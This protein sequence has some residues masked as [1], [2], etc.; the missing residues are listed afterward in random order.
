MTTV[1]EYYS[2]LRTQADDNA[3]LAAFN[4]W[5]LAQPEATRN[6]IVFWIAN[7]VAEGVDLNAARLLVM[8]AIDLVSAEPLERARMID[9]GKAIQIMSEWHEIDAR[10]RV[11][12]MA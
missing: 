7:I 11:R 4:E 12:L 10:R 5:L 9:K 1:P 3:R 8:M 2:L 6:R